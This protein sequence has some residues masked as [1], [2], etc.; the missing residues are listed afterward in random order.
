M[1]LA[2][3][4]FARQNGEDNSNHIH[5][6]K[7]IRDAFHKVESHSRWNFRHKR[8]L[9]EAEFHY[10]EGETAKAGESYDLAIAAAKDHK[11][12][13]DE[14]LA[15]ELAA[16]F[17]KEQG[18]EPKSLEMF[19]QARDAYKKWGAVKKANSLPQPMS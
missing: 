2:S 13:Q 5:E 17:Y 9:L 3:C 16:Y 11:F 18:N 12:L 6:A 8:L 1:G 4:Y 10:T 19:K 14:A 7:R 15:C